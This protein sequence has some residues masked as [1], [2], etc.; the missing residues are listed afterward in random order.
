MIIYF[1][2]SRASLEEKKAFLKG[3]FLSCGSINDP[4]KNQYHLEFFI[5]NKK[6]AETVNKLLI[7]LNFKSKILKREKEYMVYIKSSE[8]ISDFIKYLNA[9]NALFYFEDIR[10]YKDHKKY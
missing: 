4:K 3:L 8:N 7:S 5:K 9:I 6:D 1:K 10:I 2:I